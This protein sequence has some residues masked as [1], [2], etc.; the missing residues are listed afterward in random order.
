MTKSHGKKIVNKLGRTNELKER[1]KGL[2]SG[3]YTKCG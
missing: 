1:E 3:K 2:K